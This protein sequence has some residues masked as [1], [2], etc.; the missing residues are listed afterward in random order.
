MA[1]INQQ[2]WNRLLKDPSM[3]LNELKKSNLGKF[4]GS[5]CLLLIYGLTAISYDLINDLFVV[6]AL[7]F[8]ALLNTFLTLRF[9]TEKALLNIL[10]FAKFASMTPLAVAATLNLDGDSIRFSYIFTFLYFVYI[11][12]FHKWQP[13]K[14]FSLYLF[15]VICIICFKEVVFFK[16]ILF[17]VVTFMTAVA[18]GNIKLKEENLRLHHTKKSFE[19]FQSH[20]NLIEHHV[21]NSINKILF[22]N[23]SLQNKM[24]TDLDEF[25]EGIQTEIDYIEHVLKETKS[26][27]LSPF[28]YR[29]DK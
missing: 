9:S 23:L 10:H 14:F 3:E 21:L 6:V 8:F 27:D 25:T 24:N 18:R 20:N 7:I 29:K 15:A 4:I 19:L 28:N 2:E 1:I 22:Y 17:L 13:A 5:V 12:D 11:Y 16:V 26:E